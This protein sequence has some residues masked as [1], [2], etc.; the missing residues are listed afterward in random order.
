LGAYTLWKFKDDQDAYFVLVLAIM[1][2]A[3]LLAQ[4]INL[5]GIVGALLAGLT[6]NAAV[7]DKLAK[8]K[9]EFFGTSFFIPIFIIVTG[10]LIDPLSIFRRPNYQFSPG[11]SGHPRAARWEVNSGTNCGAGLRLYSG[12]AHDDVVA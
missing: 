10:F 2:V 6:V 8:E 7:H 12:R 4:S 9:L 1:A 5:P 11:L 3:G